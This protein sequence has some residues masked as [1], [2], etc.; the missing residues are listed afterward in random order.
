M[1]KVILCLVFVL[2]CFT[3]FSQRQGF[4]N[5]YEQEEKSFCA[6]SI[7]ETNDNCFIVAVYDY[8]G[9]SG[10]L[11][12]LS[13]NG[14]ML[15]TLALSEE[16]VFSSI[17][18]L[19]KDSAQQNMFFAIGHVTYW[20][21]QITKP[22]IVHFDEDLNL[23]DRIEVELPGEYHSFVTERALCTT[24]GDFI[25]ATSL[26]AQNNYHRLYMRIALDGTLE[27][28]Y[29]DSEGCGSGI[30]INAIFE[31]PEGSYFGEYRLSYETMGYLNLQLR[32]FG[33]DDG[34]VFDTI[35]EYDQFVQQLNA[36]T[37]YRMVRKTQANGTVMPLN[38]SILL[39]SDKI[40]ETWYQNMSGITY[41]SDFSTL[42]SSADLEGNMRNYLAI[43]SGN[44]TTEVPFSFNAID[45]VK[46][47]SSDD[48]VI[49]H[50]C[51]GDRPS[52]Q[53]TFLNCITLTKTDED[54]N[55]IWQKSYTHPT[56]F[57]QATYLI[58][59]HDGGCLVAGGVYDSS[60]NHYDL[61]LLKIN[62]DGTVGTEEIVVTNHPF[63]FPNPGR[64]KLK[65]ESSAENSVIRI[66]NLQGKL[67]LTKPFDYS[68]EINAESLPSGLYVW[69]I[70]HDN[71]KVANGKW[72][73][74]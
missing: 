69:E 42:L 31:F 43:G 28:F 67:V 56:R 37:T 1:N 38:D 54:L 35:H 64:D 3:A 55:V 41:G 23:I 19:F 34:F 11:M 44:D 17:S 66:Y 6:S 26:D 72:V 50:G 57:L 49:Y 15:N 47:D 13:Q 59:T 10:E 73:K 39:F 74:E 20:D 29:E 58:A 5:I 53:T 14:E 22:F 46:V 27:C 2:C 32:L 16:S 48:A 9:R 33:F 25:Y 52:F 71:Q 65:V 24:D 12:K 36:D 70:W 61:F 4:F 63:V 30:F 62:P 8:Y 18:G 7:V 45:F 51:Y 21:L 68:T 40:H 60:S